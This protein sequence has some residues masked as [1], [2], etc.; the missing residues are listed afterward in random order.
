M[1][2]SLCNTINYPTVSF[3]YFPAHFILKRT[4][5]TFIPQSMM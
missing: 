1:K 3:K 4:Y 5:F 2:F